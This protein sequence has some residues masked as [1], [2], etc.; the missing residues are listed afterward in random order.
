LLCRRPGGWAECGHRKSSIRI[1]GTTVPQQLRLNVGDIRGHS[2]AIFEIRHGPNPNAKP[3]CEGFKI[4]EV[5][6]QGFSDSID[7]NGRSWGYDTITLDN[8]DKI[9][10]SGPEPGSR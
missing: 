3:N 8:G 1:E 4:A 2:I 6:G 9:Y 5:L 10:T 7:R